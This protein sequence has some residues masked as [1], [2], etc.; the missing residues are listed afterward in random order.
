MTDVLDTTLSTLLPVSDDPAGWV[1]L[2][3]A[4]HPGLSG[5]PGEELT[6]DP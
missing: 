6:A 1:E 3:A 4:P 5:R 2:L